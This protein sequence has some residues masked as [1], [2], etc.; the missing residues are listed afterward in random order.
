MNRRHLSSILAVTVAVAGSTLVMPRPAAASVA[1][2]YQ[3][4]AGRMPLGLASLTTTVGAIQ[5]PVPG[6]TYRKF[7]QGYASS[8]WSIALNYPNGQN[9]TRDPQA[10]LDYQADLKAAGI[11]STTSTY[12]PPL[13]TDVGYRPPTDVTVFHGL[14]LTETFADRASADARLVALTKI[15]V[16]DKF[17]SG[18]VQHQAF[19]QETTTGPWEVRVVA[20]EPDAAVTV[21][22]AHGAELAYGDTVRNIAKHAG[23]IAAINASEFDIKSV[24]NPNFNGY[25]GDPLGIYVQGNNLL[26]DA[27]NGRTALLLNGAVGKPRITELTSTTK[28]T[29]PDGAVWQIDGIH[30]KPGKIINCGGVGDLRP[31][32]TPG[33]EVWRYETCTDADEIVIFRPEWGT[34]TPPGP[35][36][37]VDVVVDGNWV[38]KQLRSPAGGPIPSG[39]RVMQG[40]GGGADWLRAHTVIGQ[41]FQ[42]GTQILDP[43]GQMVAGPNFVAIG[44]GPALVR[45]GKIW[46][47]S[48]A[49]G[50]KT[51]E[52]FFAPAFHTD[53][54]PRTLVGITAAGQLL[55]V[56][57]DG[58]RPGISV[59]VTIP[60]AAEVMKWLGATD[61]MML[62]MGGDSTLVIN[63]ILYNRPTDDW[64][65][66]FTERRV[67]NAIVV[68]KK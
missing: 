62:G 63:D 8:R 42:P 47:N 13:P 19:R 46:I 7:S 5:T 18:T 39:S 32:G 56:V 61:A 22:G 16:A 44:G 10:A 14:H 54:H 52:G 55:M 33:D 24:N 57:I 25:D 23:A 43:Q 12:N 50:W 2:P 67:G 34:A 41:K 20:V 45:D 9:L 64:E 35:A 15:K 29:A 1:A 68:T 59:G 66:D 28:V 60:E 49:N 37:S 21:G 3:N 30:R 36:G 48:G 6:V 27:Q 4:P 65:Q 17:V 58:R 53:R 26:S 40:I 31:N 38:A 51:T 11:A